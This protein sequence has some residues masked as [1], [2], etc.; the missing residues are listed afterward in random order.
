MR[1]LLDTRRSTRLSSKRLGKRLLLRAH[2]HRRRSESDVSCGCVRAIRGLVLRAVPA[3]SPAAGGWDSI[4]AD[5]CASVAALALRAPGPAAIDASPP[6]VTLLR[7][8]FSTPLRF[9][10]TSTKIGSAHV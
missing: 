1:W 7:S 3:D 5:G 2:L 6:S 8:S 4:S 10:T 9:I